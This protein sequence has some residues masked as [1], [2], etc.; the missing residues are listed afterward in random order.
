VINKLIYPDCNKSYVSQTGRSFLVQYNEYKQAL[1]NNNHTSKYAQHH[2]S[3]DTL[4]HVHN[5]KESAHT[6]TVENYYFHADLTAN[7]HLNFSQNI[8]PNP[9]FDSTLKTHQQ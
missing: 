8:F 5:Q 6:N 7:I 1:T 2:H 9:I 4:K 3:F